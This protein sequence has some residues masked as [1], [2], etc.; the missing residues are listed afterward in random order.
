MG[1][2]GGF[3][4]SCLLTLRSFGGFGWELFAY[5]P[6][7]WGFGWE[8]FAYSPLIWGLWV[9][10]VCL[11]SAHLGVRGSCLLTLRSFGGFRRG[12][13]VRW[14]YTEAGGKD[15]RSTQRYTYSFGMSI[16]KLPPVYE[17]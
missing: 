13:G 17:Y 16:A 8:L 9:G 5:S 10:A 14:E 1:L 11:L 15:L 7:I 6:L 12:L 4:G 3:G 2:F